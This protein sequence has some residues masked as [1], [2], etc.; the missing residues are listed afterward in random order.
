MIT[1]SVKNVLNHAIQV[2]PRSPDDLEGWS[3]GTPI[4]PG[5]TREVY[6]C[7]LFEKWPLLKIR[8]LHD[9][10]HNKI[11]NNDPRLYRAELTGAGW[12]G[13]EW[14][15]YV[16]DDGLY[17]NPQ[18]RGPFY[19]KWSSVSEDVKMYEAQSVEAMKQNGS[20][21]FNIFSSFI[22]DV[23]ISYRVSSDKDFAEKIYL[24]LKAEGIRCFWDRN[25]IKIGSNWRD[26]FVQGLKDSAVFLPLISRAGVDHI[27]KLEEGKTDNVLYEYEIALKERQTRGMEI[28][29][30]LVGMCD[31]KGKACHK[32]DSFEGYPS[33]RSETCPSRTVEETM[34]LLFAIQGEDVDPN[35]RV[36]KNTKQIIV[37]RLN[38][39]KK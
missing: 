34:K 1:L 13:K 38:Q 36:E 29:P 24:V 21:K 20:P 37:N 25:A 16:C 2:L 15:V 5:Q 39:W 6:H 22:Y 10:L 30:L 19:G 23:F 7:G 4:Q 31:Q 26:V 14:T 3:G 18:C 11:N 35:E 27:K 12:M 8:V 28:L 33:V 17:E 32:F 9:A